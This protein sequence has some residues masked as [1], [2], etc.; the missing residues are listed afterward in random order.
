MSRPLDRTTPP[1]ADPAR[2]FHFPDTTS[3]V[4]GNGLRVLSARAPEFPLVTAQLLTPAGAMQNPLDRPGLA[5]LHGLM[6][7]EG[8]EKYDAAELA[9][10]V[11]QL[12][13]SMDSGAGWNISYTELS[14]LSDDVEQGLQLLAEMTLRSTFPEE[15]FSRLKD[16]T[17]ADLIRRPGRPNLLADDT[18]S[19][20]L[21]G[22]SP[23]GF[24]IKGTPESI[25]ALDID[26]IK[27]FRRRTFVP[28]GSTL[29]VAGDFE[30]ET[31]HRLA[32]DCFGAWTGGPKPERP[33]LEARVLDG[34][35]VHIADRPGA[36]QTQLYLGH[37]GP[38]RL[39]PEFYK[40]I[41]L[42]VL[43]G[44]KFTSRLNLNLRE[45][46]GFTYGVQSSF[47]RRL[48]PAPFTVRTAVATD[49]AGAAVKEILFEVERLRSEPVTAEEWDETL[50]YL[51]GVF[52]YTVQTTEDLASRL[53]NLAIFDLALDYYETYRDQLRSI[54]P[55][56]V[57][58]T[59]QRFLFPDRMAIVAAGPAET[60]APQLEA[61]GPVH[62]HQA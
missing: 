53:E 39:D 24:P 37:G 52:P 57:I 10:T 35:E 30:T 62:V 3:I 23:F 38:S 2:P 9:A 40:L 6:L 61:Y 58:D 45:R 17:K 28:D 44:G 54:T 7:L 48:A 25:E 22:G 34:I 42:N 32:E 41:A 19:R 1:A 16:R 29:I 60:L 55:E 51:L 8:S 20:V 59:A 50:S 26:A 4:L 14:L 47:A 56:Q 46:H 43:L 21:Y 12:G 18:F 31:L 5:D 36:A 27:T 11:E 33:T 13:S 49:V 15:P